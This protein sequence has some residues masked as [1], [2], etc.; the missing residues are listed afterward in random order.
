MTQK[1]ILNLDTETSEAENIV[2]DSPFYAELAK[3]AKRN[4]MGKTKMTVFDEYQELKSFSNKKLLLIEE[5][6]NIL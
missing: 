1:F 2:M 5:Y 4:G 3:E 6:N